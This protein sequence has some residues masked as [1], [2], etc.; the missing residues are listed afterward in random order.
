MTPYGMSPKGICQLPEEKGNC[1]KQY[2]GSG[3]SYIHHSGVSG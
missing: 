1:V 2:N 3:G